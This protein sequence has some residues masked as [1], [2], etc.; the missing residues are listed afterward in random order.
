M[1]IKSY[2]RNKSQSR[3]RCVYKFGILVIRRVIIDKVLA[4]KHVFLI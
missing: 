4:G 3:R 2:K 1:K